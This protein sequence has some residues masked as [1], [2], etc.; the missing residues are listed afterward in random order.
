M[1]GNQ[2]KGAIPFLDTLLTPQV[3]NSLSLTV[4]NKPTHTDQ[5]L[6]WNS[7]HNLSDMYSVI[8]TLTHRAKTV[9][10]RPE[11]FQKELQ[12]LRKALAKCKYIN[13]AINRVQSKYI[14]SNWK[15]NNNNNNLQ[16]N[17]PNPNANVDQA[18]Q[19][20]DNNS[21]S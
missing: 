7:Y 21:T 13:W 14:N 16:D 19:S 6:Q 11:L 10:T 17:N 3:D 12:H 18:N 1:K 2:G 8:G 9:C 15:D 4:Y 5:Y 20:K